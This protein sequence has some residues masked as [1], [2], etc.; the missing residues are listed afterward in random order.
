MPCATTER[1]VTWPPAI[2]WLPQPWTGGLTKGDCGGWAQRGKRPA[3]DHRFLDWALAGF[4]LRSS[5]YHKPSAVELAVA[6][7]DK[8][9]RPAHNSFALVRYGAGRP[10][11]A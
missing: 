3:L 5:D 1:T 8:T 10:S 6:E 7:D 2:A 9:D 4:Y 11:S